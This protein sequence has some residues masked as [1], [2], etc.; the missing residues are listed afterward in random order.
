[1]KSLGPLPGRLRHATEGAAAFVPGCRRTKATPGGLR[2]EHDMPCEMGAAMAPYAKPVRPGSWPASTASIQAGSLAS[3]A[4]GEHLAE[5][6]DMPGGGVQLGAAGHDVLQS[7]AAF[8]AQGGGMASERP[9]T[10]RTCGGGGGASGGAARRVATWARTM[11]SRVGTDVTARPTART[12]RTANAANLCGHG[13]RQPSRL[14]GDA[15]RENRWRFVR[16]AVNFRLGA[17]RY[18]ARRRREPMHG[19]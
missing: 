3:E 6:A 18:E 9:V 17:V 12:T 14:T 2:S 15:W 16:W 8:L 1:M 5:V 7:D 11:A 4:A 19:G 13:I 10:C